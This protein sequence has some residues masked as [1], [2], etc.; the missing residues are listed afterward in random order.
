MKKLPEKSHRSADKIIIRL[1]D[2]M[3]D[4]IKSIARSSHRTMNAQVVHYLETL[5]KAEQ[6]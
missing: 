3:R 1:P 2:G 4:E 5:I 6:K